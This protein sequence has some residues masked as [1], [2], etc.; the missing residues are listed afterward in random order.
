MIRYTTSAPPPTPRRGRGNRI[1]QIVIPSFFRPRFMPPSEVRGRCQMTG[2]FSTS[3]R[4]IL[5]LI[6]I[7]LITPAIAQAPRPAGK[8]TQNKYEIFERANTLYREGKISRAVIL[9][10]KAG[11]RGANPEAIAF[12]LGNCYYRL[13]NMS[14]AAAAFRRAVR[15]SGG[16]NVSALFNLAGALFR[17][18][19]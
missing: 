16:S 15:V 12:N 18:E 6:C 17:L 14:K 11:Q 8:T 13:D 19:Q 9:Y 5:F 1:P 4:L 3:V 2:S 10:R 7:S